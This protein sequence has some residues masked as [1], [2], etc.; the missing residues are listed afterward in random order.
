MTSKD[1]KQLRR[2]GFR[3]GVYRTK[4]ESAGDKTEYKIQRD[5]YL[6]GKLRLQFRRNETRDIRIFAYEVPIFTGAKRVNCLDLLGYDQD[7]NLFVIELKRADNREKLSEVLGQINEYHG[8]VEQIKENIVKE[9]REALL[10]DDSFIFN[11]VYK[12][13]LAPRKYYNSKDNKETIKNYPDKE[14]IPLFWYIGNIPDGNEQK[15]LENN[16]GK[17]FVRISFIKKKP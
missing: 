15:L 16:N 13:I 6:I 2:K 10:L 8:V 17:G 14:E 12:M 9:A 11:N 4:Q 5:I 7:Y 3:I 1:D